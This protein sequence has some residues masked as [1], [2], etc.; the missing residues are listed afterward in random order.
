VVS[1]GNS[2]SDKSFYPTLPSTAEAIKK[3]CVGSGPKAVVASVDL[4]VGGIM[5]ACYPGQLPRNEEQVSNYKRLVPVK[6]GQGVSVRSD[7]NDLYTV[8]LRAHL[9]GGREKFIRDVKAYPEPAIVLACDEQ[10]RDL[11]RFCCDPSEFSALT[12]DPTFSLGD[13]DVTPTTYHHLLLHSKRTNKPPVCLGPIMVHYRKNFQTFLFFASCMIG[14]N[15][16]LEGLRVFGTDGEKAL[17]DAFLH[18][19]KFA[20]HL[21]CF[22]LCGVI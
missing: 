5:E 15:K 20:V 4:S 21:T 12:I 16:N 1:H 8:M 19:F 13:F 10:L 6:L 17:I 9:E 3:K 11:E 18:E 2:K 22:E 14:L 7:A